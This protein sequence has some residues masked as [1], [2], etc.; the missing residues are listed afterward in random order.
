MMN[1]YDIVGGNILSIHFTPVNLTMKA[2]ITYIARIISPPQNTIKQLLPLLLSAKAP[3]TALT[4]APQDEM[5]IGE[6]NL[7][8]T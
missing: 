4:V 7:V 3:Q 2:N 5:N 1:K 8:M 6:R